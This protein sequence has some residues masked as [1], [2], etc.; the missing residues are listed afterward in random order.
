[1]QHPELHLHPDN[2]T[3]IQQMGS[4]QKEAE[5]NPNQ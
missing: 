4:S 3:K 2:E 5:L 1:M